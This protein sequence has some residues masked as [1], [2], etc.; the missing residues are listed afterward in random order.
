MSG[1]GDENWKD[2]IERLKSELRDLR[3]ELRGPEHSRHKARKRKPPKFKQAYESDFEI[4]CIV[5]ISRVPR[6]AYNH[7]WH[8]CVNGEPFACRVRVAS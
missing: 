4:D 2:E 8:A 7:L 3:Q 5:V 1:N 6:L